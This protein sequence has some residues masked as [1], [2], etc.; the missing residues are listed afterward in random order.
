MA[1][2]PVALRS[3]PQGREDSQTGDVDRFDEELPTG[4]VVARVKA[5]RGAKAMHRVVRA[6]LTGVSKIE[7]LR[8]LGVTLFAGGMSG[9]VGSLGRVGRIRRS[10]KR[11]GL[12]KPGIGIVA[13]RSTVTNVLVDPPIARLEDSSKIAAVTNLIAG[14]IGR[15]A[16]RGD[17]LLVC[18]SPRTSL[19]WNSMHLSV[20]S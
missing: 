3:V 18:R 8:K 10:G 13:G 14:P 6:T 9:I 7:E 1:E 15:I 4:R 17:E 11:G 19:A 5:R 2:K 20:R 12:R 16:P